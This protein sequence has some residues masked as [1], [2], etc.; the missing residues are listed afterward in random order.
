[1]KIAQYKKEE[2][3]WNEMYTV[4]PPIIIVGGSSGSGKTRVL[5]AMKN[6]LN[7][8]VIDLEGV[9]NHTKQSCTLA[10]P[11][12][13]L[14]IVFFGRQQ[15][16]IAKRSKIPNGKN[17]LTN[18]LLS[19]EIP[20]SLPPRQSTDVKKPGILSVNIFVKNSK[21][22]MRNFGTSGLQTIDVRI[23]AMICIRLIRRCRNDLIFLFICFVT[24]VF[25][26]LDPCSAA[27]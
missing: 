25:K 10:N 8:Q 5:L 3:E 18:H 21:M 16:Q 22:A 7:C 15:Y 23:D 19:G 27:T 6:Q 2:M 20:P 12:V 24:S 13:L 17:M 26:A 1:M 9:A 4:G 11:T 14:A